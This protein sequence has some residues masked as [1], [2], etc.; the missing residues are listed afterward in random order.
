MRF[1]DLVDGL[2]TGDDLRAAIAELLVHKR[3]ANESQYGRPWPVINAFIDAEL[4]RLEAATPPPGQWVDFSV[5][6]QLLM[7]VVIELYGTSEAR[8]TR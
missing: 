8:I 7:D 3:S 1:Q 5:L 4:S 6:D 2:L